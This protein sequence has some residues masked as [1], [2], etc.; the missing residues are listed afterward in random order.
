MWGKTEHC[1]PQI[2]GSTEAKVMI[3]SPLNSHIVPLPGAAFSYFQFHLNVSTPPI[4]A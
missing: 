2:L 4:P 3:V 1:D